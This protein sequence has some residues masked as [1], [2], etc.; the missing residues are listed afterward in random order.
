MHYV[1]ERVLCNILSFIFIINF[2]FYYLFSLLFFYYLSFFRIAISILHIDWRF[3]T[4]ILLLSR[5]QKLITKCLFLHL[6]IYVYIFMYMYIY[7]RIQSYDR[8]F[9]RSE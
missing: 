3:F 1:I 9:S 2:L 8:R 6:Y 5:E 7:S 4:E